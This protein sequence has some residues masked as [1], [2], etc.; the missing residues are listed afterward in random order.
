M[1]NDGLSY[2]QAESGSIPLL[3]TTIGD[4]LDQ[5]AEE[6]PTQEAIIYSCYPEFGDALNIRW[7]YQDYYQHANMLA[8]GL[9]ALG[10]TKGD[11]IAIWA[12]NL[13]E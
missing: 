10:L 6:L 5:H 11:H 9:M 3:E 2:W 4:L 12:A 1:T 8:K 13:P 7:T